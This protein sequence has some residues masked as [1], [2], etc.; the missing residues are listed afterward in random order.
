MELK[1]GYKQTEVGVIPNDWEVDSIGKVFRLINGRAFKPEDWKLQGTPIIRIQNLNDPDA[2]FNYLTTPVEDRHRVEAGDLLFAWSGTTG[3]S[4]GARVW[5]GPTGVLNQHIFKVIT[6]ERKLSSPFALLVFHKIQEDIEKKTHGFK[7]SFVHV[8]KSDLVGVCLP[9]PPIHE[10]RVI[11]E[12]LND[13]DALLAKLDALI[14]K[15][16]DLKQAAMQQ[17]LTGQTRLWGFDGKWEVK[18]LGDIAEMGSGGT[19]PSSVPAYYDGD[20]PWV[21]ISDMTKGGKII[22]STD[23]N[24]TNEG[25]ANSATQMFPV[26]TVLYA[27]YASLGECSVAG[28][29]LCSSQA[30]LGIRPKNNLDKD[31][32]YYHLTSLKPV[33]KAMGQHGT[34]ANLNK[35]IVQ[36]FQLRLPPLSEQ[37]AIAEVLSDMDAEIAALQSRRE[38]THSLKQGM[39]Q[40]LLTGRI[41]LV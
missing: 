2:P 14:A 30:I 31:F 8:K 36:D 23:R 4:F 16:R 11:A 12:A 15:K 6:D 29:S 18:R 17:L 10:Q 5:K 39:M 3:T 9:V 7:A 22:L 33:V 13:V 21:S 26:G 35:G 34:Q 38:K 37:T 19:P 25:F 1:P 40:E 24:L 41:R 27:M 32:L 28:I 20:I